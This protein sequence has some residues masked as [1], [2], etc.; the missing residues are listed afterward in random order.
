LL[1]LAIALTVT[2]SSADAVAAFKRGRDLLAKGSTA[3]ACAAFAE[4]HHLDPALGALINLA[5]C[6]AK[7]NDRPR[8]FAL[9]TEVLAWA[10]RKGDQARIAVAR[11][12]LTSLRGQLGLA[13]IDTPAGVTVAVDRVSVITGQTVPLEPGTHVA[14]FVSRDGTVETRTFAVNAGQT[15]S[16]SPQALSPGTKPLEE[17]LRGVVLESAVSRSETAQVQSPPAAPSRAGPMA[18]LLAGAVFAVGGAFLTG[19]STDVW[20]RGESQRL[21]G[22]LTVTQATYETA[23][24][25]YPLGLGALVGGALALAGGVLWLVL[26]R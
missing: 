2:S 21:G 23:G 1:A 14:E 22:P 12:R 5:E 6:T 4:S 16:L 18:S 3:E 20:N 26:S 8:A 11:E 7:L 24:S 17:A 19:W 13:V 9:F 10:T 15:L 25:L